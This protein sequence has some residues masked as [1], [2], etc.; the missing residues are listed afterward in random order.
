MEVI[1]D[2]RIEKPGS[3]NNPPTL[4]GVSAANRHRCDKKGFGEEGL[5]WRS[6]YR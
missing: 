5:D 2:A 6:L 4:L 1:E 3:Q